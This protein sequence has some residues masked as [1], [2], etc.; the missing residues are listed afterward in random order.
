MSWLKNG[1]LSEESL[2]SVLGLT[3]YIQHL[4][5]NARRIASFLD[6]KP[7]DRFLDSASKI[8]KKL[9]EAPKAALATP[10]DSV[11]KDSPSA[12]TCSYCAK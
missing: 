7:E 6:F 2:R 10:V 5:P 8:S 9:R 1:I 12:L 4:N 11:L 3:C